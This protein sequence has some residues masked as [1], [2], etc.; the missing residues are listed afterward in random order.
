MPDLFRQWFCCHQQALHRH[1][2]STKRRQVDRVAFNCRHHP[3]AFDPGLSS[4]HFAGLPVDD[5]T[6]LVKVNTQAFDG[7]GQAANQLGRLDRCHIRVE[8][9]AVR[10]ADA[11]LGRQ[12]FRAHPTVIVFGQTLLV[13][14]FQVVTQRGFLFRITCGTVQYATFAVVAVDVL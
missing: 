2:V 14:L 4:A 10:L 3:L 11:Q 8:D 5:R 12:F 7:T 6:V 1:L 9:S 13:E